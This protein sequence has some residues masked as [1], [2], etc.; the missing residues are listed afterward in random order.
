MMEIFFDDKPVLTSLADISEYS[1]HIS[2]SN[3]I[4]LTEGNRGLRKSFWPKPPKIRKWSINGR[5]GTFN[6]STF[7][8]ARSDAFLRSIGAQALRGGPA[9]NLRL[10][11]FRSARSDALL[12]KEPSTFIFQPSSF[13]FP[14]GTQ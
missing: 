6:L 4:L 3:S 2:Y 10:S 8:S 13:I 14:L 1:R 7:R 5:G 11:T 9:K 12:S